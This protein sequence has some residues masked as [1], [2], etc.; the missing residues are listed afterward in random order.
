ML[1]TD[2]TA[3]VSSNQEFNNANKIL[4]KLSTKL[5]K[6]VWDSPNATNVLSKR[7]LKKNEKGVCIEDSS[8]LF[9]RVA[10]AV[11]QGEVKYGMHP[12]RAETVALEYFD[13]MASGKFMPN[14]PTLMNAGR[15]LG[16]LSACFVLPIADSIEGIFDSVKTTA[17]IQR[18][19]GGTGFCLDRLRPTGDYIK[20]SGGQTSG[21]ISFWRVFAE[22]TNAISQGSF[23]RGA[24][25]MM[26]FVDSC[27]I[28]KFIHAKQ[29]L[30]Q[31]TN[32]NISVKVPD[33]WMKEFRAEP[34]SAAVVINKRT[35]KKYVIPREFKNKDTTIHN[36]RLE[37]LIEVDVEEGVMLTQP[38]CWTK[39]QIWDIICTNAHATGEPGVVF[40]DRWNETNPTPNIGKYEATNP[41]GEQ[42]LLANEA[43]NLGSLNTAAYV[44]MLGDGHPTSPGDP[45]ERLNGDKWFDWDDFAKDIR[46]STR[47]LENVVEI[48]KYP[49]PEIDAV[50][51]GN[52]KIGL[53]VM[54]FSDV[55]YLLGIQYDSEEGLAY[56][57]RIMRFINEQAHAESETLAEERGVFSNWKGSRW[58]TDWKR[59]QRNAC[60]TTVAPTGTISII[61]NCSCG[62]EPMFSLAFTRQVMPGHAGVKT[63]M[64]EA[65]AIFEAA[66]VK[67]N[68]WG[69]TREELFDAAETMGSIQH[70]DK[71]P[72]KVRQT[73]VC[74]HDIAP[75]W[76][77]KMQAAFQKH[78][79]SSI[80]K[81]TNFCHNATVADV[82]KVYDLAFDTGCKG[83]TV[84]RNGCRQQ[85]PMA[86]KETPTISV[87]PAIMLDPASTPEFKAALAKAL[88][89]WK[90]DPANLVI[91]P[92]RT[93]DI[94]SSLRVRQNTPFGHMH[95]NITV[96]PRTGKELELFAQLGKGGEVAAADLEGM[97]RMVSLFLRVGGTIDQVMEQLDGIG[98]TT[99]I[100]TK[101]GRVASMPDGLAKALRRYS[102][103]KKAHGL[104]ALL[105][106]RV[107]LNIEDSA[108]VTKAEIRP[109]N[110]SAFRVQC[111]KCSEGQLIRL[112]GCEK[113][114]HCEYSRC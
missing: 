56:G 23:R 50:C 89:D 91:K 86:L 7:Y 75:E 6:H 9:W 73:F 98:S 2:Q 83:V 41:C 70:L 87:T 30:T 19:G 112:E 21:P 24:N 28:L 81:T 88:L 109:S 58:D 95:I 32:F 33:Y 18:A 31:F 68:F 106:G 113:C 8:D 52:R 46:L 114:T 12:E 79:D 55:L 4:N 15:E 96:D 35:E 11:A 63:K 25:M 71:I 47:F 101:S 92:V 57:E 60:S 44:H 62:I 93:P 78:C 85:Q 104:D 108:A 29:D 74:A 94:L 72:L 99:F 76:H 66:A 10:K 84:Y 3:S 26:M 37:D 97:C 39:A 27:D 105:L 102:N 43:C 20:T 100:A 110:D 38:D 103:M 59:K 45:V 14:S 54:G 51:R 34:N 48:N 61:A 49:T 64:Y 40:P 16:L 82:R 53:G 90:K 65:N 1:I 36:S 69:Y 13:L 77:I 111:Q 5:Q 107:D 67:N 17:L 22:A 80:S 42:I